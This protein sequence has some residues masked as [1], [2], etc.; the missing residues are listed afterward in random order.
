MHMLNLS[1]Q[2]SDTE[3]LNAILVTRDSGRLKGLEPLRRIQA[4]GCRQNLESDFGFFEV[5]KVVG[6]IRE[7]LL[8]SRLELLWQSKKRLRHGVIFFGVSEDSTLFLL[9]CQVR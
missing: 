9:F 8:E 2:P 5:T 3:P 1:F 6:E 7:V 4:V